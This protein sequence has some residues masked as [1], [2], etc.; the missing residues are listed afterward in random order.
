MKNRILILAVSTVLT[1][2]CVSPK[3]Y[4]DLESKYATLK[5]ENRELKTDNEDLLSAKNAAQN[6]LEQ[7]QKAYEEAIAERD[8]LQSDYKATKTNLENLKASYDALEKNSSSAIAE[9]VQKNR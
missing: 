4:K 1:T 8:K 5:D 6:E 3:V 2:S 7:L 9:N